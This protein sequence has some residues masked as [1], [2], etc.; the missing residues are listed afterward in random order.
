MRSIKLMFLILVLMFVAASCR[1]KPTGP[2]EATKPIEPTQPAKSLLQAAAIGDY[3]R[4]QLLVSDGANVGERDAAGHSAL[5]LAAQAGHYRAAEILMAKGADVAD[6]TRA[7][8]QS[9]LLA[10]ARGHI[11]LVKLLVSKGADANA[12]YQGNTASMIAFE[13]GYEDVAELLRA[14][15]S[16]TR[17]WEWPDPYCKALHVLVHGSGEGT[18]HAVEELL[19]KGTPVNVRNYALQT[20]LHIA[21]SE[22]DTDTA[23]VLL[24]YGADVHAKDEDGKTPLHGVNNK[25]VAGLLIAAGASVNAMRACP[26]IELWRS[27]LLRQAPM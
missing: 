13:N 11:N 3:Q 1:T 2:A 19:R 15:M 7:L 17:E 21:A 23:K 18:T 12:K 16:K 26:A 4:V 9:L 6:N 5:H 8:D 25:D 27:A 24:R 22:A 10:A 14:L 20:P